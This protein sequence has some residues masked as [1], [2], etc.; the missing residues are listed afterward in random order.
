MT[1]GAG[2][3]HIPAQAGDIYG[4]KNDAKNFVLRDA[5]TG[6]WTATTKVA[7]E[8]TDQ[9]HQAGMILYTDDGNFVKFGRIATETGGTG[10]E[11]F[12]FILETN[13]T[14][15]N[16]AADSTAEHPG[17]VPEGLLSSGWSRTGRT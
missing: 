13:G 15:R 11:K 4:D 10:V 6:A 17:R 3:L 2:A 1:V 9:W 5:P 12:E 8:G 7:F 16:E 14:P